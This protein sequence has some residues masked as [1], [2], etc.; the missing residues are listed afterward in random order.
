MDWPTTTWI[1]LY[2]AV[3]STV[4]AAWNIR[5]GIRDR[6]RL[7]FDLRFRKVVQGNY[8]IDAEDL[9]GA[10]LVLTITNAGRRPVTINTWGGEYRRTSGD[11]K[12]FFIVVPYQLPKKLDESQQVDEF[13]RDFALTFSRGARQMFVTDSSGRRWPIPKSLVKRAAR[14]FEQLGGKVDRS[15]RVE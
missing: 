10:V 11:Q 15:A 8:L 6:A 7:V 12:P 2:A 1:A 4:T 14:D 9:D 3:V 13:A 5:N